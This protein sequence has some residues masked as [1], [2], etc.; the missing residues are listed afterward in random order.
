MGPRGII[1]PQEVPYPQTVNSSD[2]EFAPFEKCY[3]EEAAPIW[4]AYCKAEPGS[5]QCRR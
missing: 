3:Q 4:G 5:A 1:P 2:G